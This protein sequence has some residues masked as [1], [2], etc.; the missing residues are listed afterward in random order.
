MPRCSPA[1]VHIL[2]YI[3][4][5]FASPPARQSWC[6]ARGP[7]RLALAP[8]LRPRRASIAPRATADPFAP[9]P[10]Q[11][12]CPPPSDEKSTAQRGPRDAVLIKKLPAHEASLTSAHVLS[13]AGSQKQ[14]ISSSL[15]RAARP[16]R[17]RCLTFSASLALS[18]HAAPMPTC[19]TS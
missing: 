3:M 13:D 2:D 4:H 1:A 17:A 16:F 11:G 18:P 10:G 8:A 9:L 14:I 19:C 6:F 12:A 15:V 7:A 5:S